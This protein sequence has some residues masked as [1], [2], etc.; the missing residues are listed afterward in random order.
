MLCNLR[1]CTNPL[2]F[3]ELAFGPDTWSVWSI[4]PAV[5][6][7]VLRF[8]LQLTRLKVNWHFL[9][10]S[11]TIHWN[12]LIIFSQITWG[13]Y[14]VFCF[15]SFTSNLLSEILLLLLSY[16]HWYKRWLLWFQTF[17]VSLGSPCYNHHVA[18]HFVSQSLYW[19]SSSFLLP[20]THP[21]EGRLFVLPEKGML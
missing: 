6:L 14:L 11:Q 7:A 15:L 21:L 4:L 8:L 18:F 13:S 16:C 19:N 1:P 9:P 3:K 2:K 5:T 10:C 17:N 12:A 20:K